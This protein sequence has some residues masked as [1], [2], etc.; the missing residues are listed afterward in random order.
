[1]SCP[2]SFEISVY[3]SLFWAFFCWM[4]SKVT[5]NYSWVDR[6]WSILPT[7][8]CYFFLFYDFFC[9]GFFNK[10]QII[11]TFL[12]TLW[13]I[14]LTFNYYR[15]GGY[16]RGSEDYRWEYVRKWI[17]NAFLFELLNIFF[18]SIIQ[19]ILLLYIAIPISISNFRN[20]INYADVALILLFLTFL[21]IESIADEQQWIFQSKKYELLKNNKK[22]LLKG[23]YKRGFLTQGL[24]NYSRHPNFL[25]EMCIWWTVYLFSVDFDRDYPNFKNW[26]IFGALFLSILF[27]C[28]TTLTELISKGKY[29][30]YGEYQKEVSRFL[31]WFNKKKKE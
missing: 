30:E 11:V 13:S 4:A 18:I 27:Q 14:R 6:L 16:K 24:F 2:S 20:E 25:A 22:E 31:F 8:Y 15:K 23:D 9:N 26:T 5:G 10:R 19:N 21:A 29:P 1:M 17:N 28:S 12:C 3:L 7:S